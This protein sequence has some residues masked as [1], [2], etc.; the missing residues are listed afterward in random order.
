[1]LL[2]TIDELNVTG[3]FLLVGDTELRLLMTE[4]VRHYQEVMAVDPQL[5]ARSK[6]SVNHVRFNLVKPSFNL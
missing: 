4:T 6:P 3:K 5:I 1:M 2:G